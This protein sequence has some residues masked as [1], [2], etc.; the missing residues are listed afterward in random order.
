M[1]GALVDDRPRSLDGGPMERGTWLQL[2]RGVRGRCRRQLGCGDEVVEVAPTDGCRNGIW[3]FAV[4]SIGTG[5]SS[6]ESGTDKVPLLVLRPGKPV[7]VAP[8]G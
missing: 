2:A 3:R 8:M 6:S 7:A 4:S 1:Y 5:L